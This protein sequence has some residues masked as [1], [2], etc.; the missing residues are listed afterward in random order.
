MPKPEL[1][2]V[3]GCNAAGKS[4]FIRTRLNEL[5]GFSVLMTDVYKSRTKELATA[6]IASGNS[7]IIE[8][9]F[10][11]LSF[12]ELADQARSA[13]YLSSLI[14]LF[15]DNVGQSKT[16]S[17]LRIMQQQ[18]LGLTS[19]NVQINFNES[20]KNISNS[21]FY[22]DYTNFFYTGEGMLNTSVMSFHQADLL[23][24]TASTLNYP[25]RFADYTFQQGFLDREAYDI[26]KANQDYPGTKVEPNL[27]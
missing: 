14:V 15:L 11:D 1:I 25:Q 9:V 22:F 12:R 18:G 4:S 19:G 20:F 2:F 23:S 7:V 17:S 13:G 6:A 21:F 26:I 10:N 5:G 27:Y 16:R 3:A 24:Y 8:T